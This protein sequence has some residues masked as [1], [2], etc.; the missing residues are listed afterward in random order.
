ME[1][2]V[3]GLDSNKYFSTTKVGS[4]FSVND[5]WMRNFP[6]CVWRG[7]VITSSFKTYTGLSTILTTV[8]HFIRVVKRRIDPIICAGGLHVEVR[9]LVWFA[10]RRVL[11]EE[12]RKALIS[13]G[14]SP[15]YLPSTQIG[16]W[17][18]C[19]SRV[20]IP[21]ASLSNHLFIRIHI[22]AA[23]RGRPADGDFFETPFWGWRSRV[24]AV[25]CHC[26]LHPKGRAGWTTWQASP[27][28]SDHILKCQEYKDIPAFISLE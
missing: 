1:A 17:P 11:P 24:F 20:S 13:S 27:R 16:S 8:V 18:F 6:G 22:F 15:W 21:D 10:W 14:I 7:K 9:Q 4:L 5:C 2:V 12:N 3:D 19:S 28:H 25:H 26:G 23:T